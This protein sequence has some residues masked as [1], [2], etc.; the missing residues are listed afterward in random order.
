MVVLVHRLGE[1]F[2]EITLDILPIKD[3]YIHEEIVPILAE[4]L[5]ENIKKSQFQIDPIIVDEKTGVILDGMH[6]Y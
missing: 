3:L 4:R 5:I 1:D 6:R 2:F